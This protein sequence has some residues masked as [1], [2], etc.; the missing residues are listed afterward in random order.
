MAHPSLNAR[1]V[2]LIR[3]R[4]QAG[5][6][7]AEAVVVVAIIGMLSVIVVPNFMSY[8]RATKIKS[9]VTRL[10]MDIR[11]ARARAVTNNSTTMVQFSFATPGKYTAFESTDGKAIT[12]A[13][14]TWTALLLNQ[15]VRPAKDAGQAKLAERQFQSPVSIVKGNCD[16]LYFYNNGTAE[17]PAG[18]SSATVLVQT[19]DKIPRSSYTIQVTQTGKVTVP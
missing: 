8:Y 11:S 9:A 13:T 14:K 1:P 10:Q 3:R 7:L 15:P 5:F 12:D 2:M 18:Q 17:V 4:T 16:A 19:S 6:S